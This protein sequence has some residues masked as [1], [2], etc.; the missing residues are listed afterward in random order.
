MQI[1]QPEE[2]IEKKAEETSKP[3][4]DFIEVD[5]VESKPQTAEEVPAKEESEQG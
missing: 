1:T 5:E 2:E 4:I 3:A